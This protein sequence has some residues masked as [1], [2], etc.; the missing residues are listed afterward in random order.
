MEVVDKFRDKRKRVA[1]L[2]VRAFRT[3]ES[4]TRWREPSF[5]LMKKIGEAI[6]DL[7]E[8]ILPDSRFS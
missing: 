6:S 2:M 8:Q 4:C 5:F 7:E 1:I 3:Q